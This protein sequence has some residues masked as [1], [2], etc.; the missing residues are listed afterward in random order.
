MGGCGA[1]WRGH[2]LERGL[3]A[4][5]CWCPLSP[6]STALP[7]DMPHTP[8][9]E[10]NQPSAGLAVGDGHGRLLQ[11]RAI[12]HVGRRQ[13]SVCVCVCVCVQRCVRVHVFTL[14]A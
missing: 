11:T 1:C 8:T 9:I 12:A 4:A 2:G 13:V 7:A 10:L 3:A 6:L 14:R 5:C